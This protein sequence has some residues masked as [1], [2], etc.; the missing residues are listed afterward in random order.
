MDEHHTG[1]FERGRDRMRWAKHNV[2][3]VGENMPAKLAAEG[4]RP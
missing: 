2:E 3:G 4:A 1:M